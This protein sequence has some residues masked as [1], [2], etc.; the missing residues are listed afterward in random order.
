M[1]IYQNAAEAKIAEV[2]NESLLALGYELVRLKIFRGKGSSTVQVM[3]DRVDGKAITIADCEA[4]S[5]HAA[6]LLDKENAFS[7]QYNLEV[8]SAGIDRP[9]TRAK[10]FIANI[11]KEVK[12][13]TIIP[14]GGQKNFT[15]LLLHADEAEIKLQT[16]DNSSEF[17]MNYDNI[18]EAKLIVQIEDLLPKRRL[19]QR[20]I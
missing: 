17:S 5:R 15:G 14:Y 19:P 11:G 1:N 6:V 18:A 2:I 12:L 13:S 20:K 8:S 9:L 7:G 10:D 3:L 16:K 4:A